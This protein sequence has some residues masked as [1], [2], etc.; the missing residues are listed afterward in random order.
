[1]NSI[2]MIYKAPGNLPAVKRVSTDV[3]EIQ[4]T[5]GGYTDIIYLNRSL[6]VVLY[7][8]WELLDQ[9]PNI[10]LVTHNLHYVGQEMLNGS[11]FVAAVDGEGNF[12]DLSP[13]RIDRCLGFLRQG[14][15]SD[16]I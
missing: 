9:R 11:L 6:V 15:L 8:C 13:Y 2:R 1:M 4:Y 10:R 12:V 16:I 7:E 5:V 14:E 3:P